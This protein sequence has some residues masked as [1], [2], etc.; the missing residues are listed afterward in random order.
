MIAYA[1][2]PY[3]Y[4]RPGH[5]YCY[6]QLQR[7]LLTRTRHCYIRTYP[8]MCRFSAVRQMKP[9][10]VILAWLLISFVIALRWPVPLAGAAWENVTGDLAGRSSECGNLNLVSS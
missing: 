4:G 1:L 8:C 7:P 10:P 3:E 6:R 9:G 5:R 2:P